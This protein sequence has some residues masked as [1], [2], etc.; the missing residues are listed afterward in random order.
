MGLGAGALRGP[1]QAVGLYNVE[2]GG[3][4]EFVAPPGAVIDVS[5]G[6]TYRSLGSRRTALEGPAASLG[7][8]LAQPLL[9]TSVLRLGVE[10]RFTLAGLLSYSGGSY[11]AGA[12]DFLLA[13]SHPKWPFEVA[14]GPSLTVASLDLEGVDEDR[15][16]KP[17]VFPSPAVLLRL[18]LAGTLPGTLDLVGHVGKSLSSEGWSYRDLQLV[19][20]LEL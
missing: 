19:L 20:A 6:S 2:E 17:I 4:V 8:S 14:V 9:E 7:V 3:A 1:A 12:G 18:Q 5:G 13:A 10:E 15:V 16:E 11:I